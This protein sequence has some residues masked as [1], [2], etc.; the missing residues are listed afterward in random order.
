MGSTYDGNAETVHSK[1][2]MNDCRT[3][4]KGGFARGCTR[5]W[6]WANSACVLIVQASWRSSSTR[7][8]VGCCAMSCQRRCVEEA[9]GTNDGYLA[10]SQPRSTSSLQYT[11]SSSIQAAGTWRSFARSSPAV[12][13]AW[14]RRW[15]S[16][17]SRPRDGGPA[18]R[19]SIRADRADGRETPI[20]SYCCGRE[21]P[22]SGSSR[23]NRQ[24]R[25]TAA[26]SGRLGPYLRKPVY[27]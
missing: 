3:H 1:K 15:S 17:G 9:A 11:S 21:R 13:P 7:A 24:S 26:A 27:R 6:S 20:P 16:L 18:Q 5:L 14:S 8:V 19:S 10:S 4:C 2:E 12:V 22:R 23:C 25:A